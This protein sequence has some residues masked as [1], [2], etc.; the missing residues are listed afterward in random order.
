[1]ANL[2]KEFLPVTSS[3]KTK[4]VTAFDALIT[5]IK[6]DITANED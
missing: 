3:N 6:E 4:L 2:V 1:M 5:K